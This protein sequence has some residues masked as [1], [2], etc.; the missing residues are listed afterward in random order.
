VQA[1]FGAF[2]KKPW[3]THSNL[4]IEIARSGAGVANWPR[5]VREDLSLAE[6]VRPSPSS[7]SGSVKSSVDLHSLSISPFE[8]KRIFIHPE[9][10]AAHEA[11]CLQA[12]DFLYSRPVTGTFDL[13]HCCDSPCCFRCYPGAVCAPRS[14]RWLV[15]FCPAQCWNLLRH[16]SECAGK[17]LPGRSGRSSALRGLYLAE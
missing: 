1:G 13:A 2:G 7:M 9:A 15:S 17:W 11:G 14:C 8:N 10:L 6:L 4:G 5:Y 12:S 16:C 3:R